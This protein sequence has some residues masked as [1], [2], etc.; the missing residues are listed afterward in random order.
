MVGKRLGMLIG[1]VICAAAVSACGAGEHANYADN[2]GPGYVQLG[3]LNYQVQVSRQ[4][5]Q[6][7]A[8]DKYYLEGFTKSQL[9]LPVADAGFTISMQ[10]YNWT[11]KAHT[12]TDDFF[13]SDTLGQ[14][15]KP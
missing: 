13:V 10:V 3:G 9:V 12:P 4:L 1:G 7:S 14:R 15:Y 2:E 5:N 6:W 8:E 11:G